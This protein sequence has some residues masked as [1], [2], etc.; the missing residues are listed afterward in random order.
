MI[1]FGISRIVGG[2]VGRVCIGRRRGGVGSLFI[3]WFIFRIM[4]MRMMIMMW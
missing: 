4:I 3:F 2:G 1:F